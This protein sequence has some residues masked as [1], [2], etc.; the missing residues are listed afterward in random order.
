M[1]TRV[2]A[3]TARVSTSV[4][5]APYAAATTSSRRAPLAPAIAV[6]CRPRIVAAMSGSGALAPDHLRRMIDVNRNPEFAERST[7]CGKANL[8]MT[9]ASKNHIAFDLFGNVR[10]V[11]VRQ[12]IAIG[13]LVLGGCNQIIGFTDPKLTGDAN[14]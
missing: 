1:R 3:W 14:G 10:Y 11:R 6:G 12:V 8:L 5:R 7:S 13:A 9:L 4:R 2:P